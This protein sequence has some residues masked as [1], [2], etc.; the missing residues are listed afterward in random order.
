MATS[1]LNQTDLE[2]AISSTI[3]QATRQQILDDLIAAGIGY[4]SPDDG[5][6]IPV[7]EGA[8][9][10]NP[11]PDANVLIEINPNNT[12]YVDANLK[13][14]IEATDSDVMLSVIGS[15]PVL[16]ATGAGND[17][18]SFVSSRGT[19]FIGDTTVFA[20]AG[21]DTVFGGGASELHGGSGDDVLVSGSVEEGKPS[22]L[23]GG[24][25]SDTLIG[26]W[27]DDSLYGGDGDDWLSAGP[28][29]A[30]RFSTAARGMTPSSVANTCSARR[31]RRRARRRRRRRR[32]LRG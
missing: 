22:T 26:G 19:D 11:D 20:G 8:A 27:G 24:T 23:Y 2:A 29:L 30:T 4:T 17:Y 7:Q 14:I 28:G 21:N 1:N 10:S 31:L 6:T 12:V 25:G 18:V 5:A 32:A 13:A 9:I 16:V 15:G 3:D